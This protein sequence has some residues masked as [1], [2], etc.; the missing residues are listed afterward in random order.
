MDLRERVW[1]DCQ[2]GLKTAVVAQKYS[3]SESWVRRLKPRHKATGSRARRPPSTGRPI[4][5][6]PHE[7]RVRELVRET[8]D[9]TL[10][11]LRQ[12]LGVEVSTGALFNYL[13]RLRLSFKKK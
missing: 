3:V 13:R 6:A 5:L 11:E 12:K 9:A 10:E 1:A 8:P 2:T 7:A 4:V